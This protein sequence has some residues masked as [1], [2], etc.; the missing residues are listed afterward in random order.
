VRKLVIED[1]EGIAADLRIHLRQHGCVVEVVA[2]IADSCSETAADPSSG[3][4]ASQAAV[5]PHKRV[6][7]QVVARMNRADD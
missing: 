6:A 5:F 7:E 4:V 2:S 3:S 1:D